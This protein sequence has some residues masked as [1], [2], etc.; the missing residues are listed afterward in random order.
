MCLAGFGRDRAL[1]IQDTHVA[2]TSYGESE[3]I[4]LS[5]DFSPELLVAKIWWSSQVRQSISV[6]WQL[7]QLRDNAAQPDRNIGGKHGFERMMIKLTDAERDTI[8]AALRRWQ[9]YPAA[10]EADLI[11]T[12]GGKHR[13]LDNS[14]IERICKRMTKIERRRDEPLRHQSNNG[15]QE[16]NAFNKAR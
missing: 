14:A 2:K 6:K 16:R 9:S 5:A 13:P 8:L 1:Q 3:G 12:S 10:R 7:L 4:I 15:A 11:A